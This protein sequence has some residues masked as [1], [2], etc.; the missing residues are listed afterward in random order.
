MRRLALPLAF[1]VLSLGFAPAPFRKPDRPGWPVWQVNLRPLADAP[2]SYK[3]VL[4]V[5]A[6]G[7]RDGGTRVDLRVERG[8]VS[9]SETRGDV[10]GDL[11]WLEGLSAAG[12]IRCLLLR[13]L[14]EGTYG[15]ASDDLVEL[16]SLRGR[17]VGGVEVG[18]WQGDLIVPV[19]R[20][21]PRQR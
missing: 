16:H 18:F 15:R 17:P 12:A 4:F 11:K 3:L 14:G 10:E 19:T 6:E 13:H 8:A 1:A 20:R 5:W 7:E 21:A 9:V 2:R